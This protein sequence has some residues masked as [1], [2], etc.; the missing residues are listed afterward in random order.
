MSELTWASGVLHERV[1][2]M[3]SAQNV[4]TRIRNAAKALGWKF[5]RAREIWYADDRVAMRPREMRR[6]EEYTGLRY[7]QD[8]LRT[9]NQLIANADALLLVQDPDFASAFAVGLRA[10]IGALD[11]SRAAER[12]ARSGGDRLGGSGGRAGRD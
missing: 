3:G 7:G 6:I 4:E 11:R 8:E 1:A 12:H 2:P 5:S 9:V 10:F